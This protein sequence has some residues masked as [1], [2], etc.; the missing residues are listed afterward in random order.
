[1]IGNSSTVLWN[2][3]SAASMA[4]PYFLA[5]STLTVAPAPQKPRTA[6][7]WLREQVDEVCRLARE[8]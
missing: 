5:A 7:E 1:M 4:T 2:S 8:A 6:L 3:S